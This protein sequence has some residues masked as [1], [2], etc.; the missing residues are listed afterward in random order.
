M[1]LQLVSNS[2]RL[3]V[4]G[5]MAAWCWIG[6]LGGVGYFQMFMNVCEGEVGI[7]YGGCWWWSQCRGYMGDEHDCHV[8]AKANDGPFGF[9]EDRV[10]DL[11]YYPG[12]LMVG[13][14]S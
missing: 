2:V 14:A 3:S 10:V 6:A 4:L 8:S 12:D 11:G 9:R 1:E 5:G 13:L 7:D